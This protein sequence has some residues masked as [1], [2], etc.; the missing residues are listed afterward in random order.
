M[1]TSQLKDKLFQIVNQHIKETYGE[2]PS[3][4]E[5]IEVIISVNEFNSEWLDEANEFLE[6]NN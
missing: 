1:S 5:I 3:S 4:K 6:N 2:N